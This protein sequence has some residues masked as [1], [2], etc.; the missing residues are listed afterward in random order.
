MPLFSQIILP[1]AREAKVIDAL[2]SDA[3]VSAIIPYNGGNSLYFYRVYVA[4]EGDNMYVTRQNIWYS[5]KM[6]DDKWSEPYRLFTEN[7]YEGENIIFGSSK[8]GNKVY[9]FHTTYKENDEV[10][11]YIGYVEKTG[12]KW[13]DIQ[14]ITIPGITFGRQYYHFYINKDED[15]ILV[16]RSKSETIEEEDI[17]VSL[18]KEDGAWSAPID[19]GPT[20]NTSRIEISPFISQDKKWL[21]YSS[22]GMG[23]FG[24]SD[25]FVSYRLDDS[26]TKW[27]KPVN[28]GEPVNSKG[29]DEN[30]VIGQ[31][32]NF[33]F[34][35][36]RNGPNVQIFTVE[37]TSPTAMSM[38]Y[39]YL[40]ED[41]KAYEEKVEVY[42]AKGEKLDQVT[43]D[44]EGRITYIMPVKDEGVTY[45]INSKNNVKL[46]SSDE[47]GNKK[48]RSIYTGDN[49]LA[50][51]QLGADYK[52]SGTLMANGNKVANEKIVLKDENDY[53]VAS[54]TTDAEGNFTF[55]K[56]KYDKQLTIASASGNKSYE[57]SNFYL[58]DGSGNKVKELKMQNGMLKEEYIKE[59]AAKADKKTANQP[60][61]EDWNQLGNEEKMIRFDFSSAS[62][63]GRA[64]SKVD[65]LANYLKKNDK[66]VTLIGHTDEKGDEEINQRMG[67][68]RANAVK[69]QLLN[70]GVDASRIKVESE[71]ENN[72]YR[73][74][75]SD[76]NRSLNRR[77][78]V[79]IG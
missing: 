27:T 56:S 66:K 34:T 48:S 73:E 18:K 72:P 78:E 1:Q 5:K 29:F 75:T 61:K 42:N 69:R 62:L 24:G 51:D 33:F 19:L 53:T 23:G 6:G 41:G 21:Y 38:G 57:F 30:F 49:W 31:D 7:D 64:K 74:N 3:E 25:V 46:Y 44:R 40:L 2:K 63:D 60:I 20:I 54:T 36:D 10:E 14:K 47:N 39:A 55:D 59:V 8:D 4:G 37:P 45:K 16:S 79:K 71:G 52:I 65:A 58:K 70:N 9:I 68:S 17:F 43:A 77:V 22:E 12:N 11:R 26:W 32:G 15:V 35:S 50:E 28:M 76:E 13:S 67:M